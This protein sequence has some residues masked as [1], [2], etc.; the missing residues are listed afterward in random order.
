MWPGTGFCGAGPVSNE[1]GAGPPGRLNEQ[2][3]SAGMV[4]HKQ[5]A[6]GDTARCGA[7]RP[8]GPEQFPCM[9]C[10]AKQRIAGRAIQ[11]I[12]WHHGTADAGRQSAIQ[13]DFRGECG[14]LAGSDL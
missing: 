6:V 9:Q 7:C 13:L 5:A 4:P 1:L 8:L 12:S 14:S 2:R 3:N 11:L 10:G